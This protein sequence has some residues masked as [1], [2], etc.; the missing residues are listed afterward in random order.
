M[1]SCFTELI[2]HNEVYCAVKDTWS[3]NHFILRFCQIYRNA[4]RHRGTRQHS[5]FFP[6]SDRSVRL[7][8]T[9]SGVDLWPDRTGKVNM[10][11]KPE[12]QQYN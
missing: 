8:P 2:F 11:L 10:R 6:S 12:S 1:A 5:Y 9:A 3:S 4:E 7:F